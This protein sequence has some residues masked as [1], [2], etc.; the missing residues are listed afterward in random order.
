MFI[1]VLLLWLGLRD[2]YL[3][4]VMA[5]NTESLNRITNLECSVLK[6][7]YLSV[8]IVYFYSLVLIKKAIKQNFT[9][10]FSYP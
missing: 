10:I 6:N 9:F 3:P 5:K 7:L 1:P 8:K 2:S 4:N